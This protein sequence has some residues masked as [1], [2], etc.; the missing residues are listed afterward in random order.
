[1]IQ[2]E[3]AIGGSVITKKIENEVVM[4]QSTLLKDVVSQ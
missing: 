1:M 3:K 4:R 2:Q